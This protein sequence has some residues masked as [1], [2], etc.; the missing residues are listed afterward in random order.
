MPLTN[1]AVITLTQ[2]MEDAMGIAL[3]PANLS[4]PYLLLGFGVVMLFYQLSRWLCRKKV[5]SISMS[6]ALKVAME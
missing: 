4:L 3:P 2:T 5:D 6:E 1:A